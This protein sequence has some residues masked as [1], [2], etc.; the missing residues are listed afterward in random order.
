MHILM[1]I[2]LYRVF[3]QNSLRFSLTLSSTGGGGSNSP[4]LVLSISHG[5]SAHQK[6]LQIFY[7]FYLY[8]QKRFVYYKNRDLCKKLDPN[9]FTID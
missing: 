5:L 2:L 1:V 9:I 7:F 3:L 6:G 8:V 4:K